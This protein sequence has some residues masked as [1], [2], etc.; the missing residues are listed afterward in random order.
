[1]KDLSP[2]LF[3]VCK[4]F[5]DK[6]QVIANE[7][8]DIIAGQYTDIIDSFISELKQLLLATRS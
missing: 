1:M 2:G 3:A 4:G 7:D 6:Y 8:Y 5:V